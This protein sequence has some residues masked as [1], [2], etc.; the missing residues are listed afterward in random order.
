MGKPLCY[1]KSE[2][3]SIPRGSHTTRPPNL[4]T[5]LSQLSL[6]QDVNWTYIRRS[7]YVLY[8]LGSYFR[9]REMSTE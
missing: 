8:L 6:F 7:I 2:T 5:L 9:G 3:G 1:Y 4:L